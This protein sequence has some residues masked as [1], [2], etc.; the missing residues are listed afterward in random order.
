MMKRIACVLGIG[1]R[2]RD[3]RPLTAPSAHRLILELHLLKK[4][5]RA[6][7]LLGGNLAFHH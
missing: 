6:L 1:F 4:G 7:L 3:V 2:S 5:E